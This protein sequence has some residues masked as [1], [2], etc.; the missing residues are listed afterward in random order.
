MA[1]DLTFLSPSGLDTWET[2]SICFLAGRKIIKM[3]YLQHTMCTKSP[4][5]NMNFSILSIKV[6]VKSCSIYKHT[7]HIDALMMASK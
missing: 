4:L 3:S 7:K 2:T 5:G 1:K 6:D